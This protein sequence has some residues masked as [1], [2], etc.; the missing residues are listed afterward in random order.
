MRLG[1]FSF[2]FVVLWLTCLN[3]MFICSVTWLNGNLALAEKCS[4]PL[5]F[6]LRQVLL[7]IY[8][9]DGVIGIFHQHNPSGRIVALGS[10]QHV[11]EIGTRNISWGSKGGRC[12]RLTTLSLLC[13]DCLEILWSS[14]SWNPQG[15]SR[16]VMDSLQLPNTYVPNFWA[17]LSAI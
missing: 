16:T 9:P 2:F 7:Y 5:R 10:T 8:I 3:L 11:K 1:L 17:Q 6:R 12:V 14:T 13:A 4:G 15:L